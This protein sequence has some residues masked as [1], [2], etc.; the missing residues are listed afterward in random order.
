MV[1]F[2]DLLYFLALL[3]GQNQL[4]LS[5]T[6]QRKYNVELLEKVSEIRQLLY[7]YGLFDMRII[8]TVQVNVSFV[9][10]QFTEFVHIVP[11][12]LCIDVVAVECVEAEPRA[13]RCG[14]QEGEG[15]AEWTC[16]IDSWTR[17]ERASARGGRNQQE[18]RS[19][20]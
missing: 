6:Q 2:V 5:H 15:V 4:I 12:C 18:S 7:L 16:K 10:L 13:M 11:L 8:V 19:V 9:C 20:L 3:V 17:S 14:V 1:V